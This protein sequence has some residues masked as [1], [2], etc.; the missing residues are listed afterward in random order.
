[1]F[2]FT[3]RNR[4]PQFFPRWQAWTFLGLAIIA[5]VIGLTSLEV[6]AMAAAGMRY[7][8]LYSMLGLSYFFLAKAV[9]VLP[10]SIVYAVWEGCGVILISLLSAFVFQHM[11]QFRELFGLTL[12]VV[13]IVLIHAGEVCIA[14][15]VEALSPIK[16]LPNVAN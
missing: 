4:I 13:G 2:L 7:V 10:V 11:L 16:E 8:T 12:A 1:M 6:D 9:K 3:I 15:Q 14:P 5:E